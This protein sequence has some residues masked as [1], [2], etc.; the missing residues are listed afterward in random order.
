M[1]AYSIVHVF[2]FDL[3]KCLQLLKGRVNKRKLSDVTSLPTFE[4][5]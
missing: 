5:T 2:K 4:L 3:R 1:Q